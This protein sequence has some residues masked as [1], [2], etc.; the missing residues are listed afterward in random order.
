MIA[1]IL[2]AGAS[3]RFGR[4]K[5]IEPID[6][7]PMIQRVLDQIPKGLKVG[8]VTGAYDQEVRECLSGSAVEF[9][10]NKDHSK[11]M[12][13][14]VQV[15][16]QWALN[17]QQPLL[18]TLGDLPFVSEADYLKLIENM[19]ALPVFS[20]MAD[21]QH[22]PPAVFPVQYLNLLK[23][24][25]DTRGAKFVITEFETQTILSAAYDVDHQ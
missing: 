1:V 20:E 16:A 12:G 4:C 9:L 25:P 6:G 17:A 10:Y 5:L 2:A 3:K 15:A 13:T 11:G 24:C 18:L 23:K 14:S 22:G 7:K 21:G 8:I 19:T